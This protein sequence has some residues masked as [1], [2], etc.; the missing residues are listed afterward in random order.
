[1]DPQGVHSISSVVAAA[2]ETS[3]RGHAVE[4]APLLL[5]EKKILGESRGRFG[6]VGECPR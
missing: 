4:R 1:M 2:G 5:K 6:L 3:R